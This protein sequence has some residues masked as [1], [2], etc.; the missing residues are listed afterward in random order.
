MIQNIRKITD[1]GEIVSSE[2]K[3][4]TDSMTADGYRIPSH[5]AGCRYFA[6]V[7]LPKCM[8]Y[9]DK[10][11]MYDLSLMMIGDTNLLGY[12][13]GRKIYAYTAVEIGTLVG[14]TGS[15]GRD[16]V[17]RMCD[18]NVIKRYDL[19][20]YV[21]PVYF[22]ASGKRLTLSL[23]LHFQAELVPLLPRWVIN[24]FLRQAKDKQV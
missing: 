11:R 10:G 24:E 9:Q 15:R 20:Y 2:D 5:K 6:D 14:L 17:K 22:L 4:F 7:P 21:S 18:L 13:Q 3:H 12:K 16:F 19:G 1:D 23:Y 8:T